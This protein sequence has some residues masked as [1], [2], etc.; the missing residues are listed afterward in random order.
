[1]PQQLNKKLL[2]YYALKAHLRYFYWQCHPKWERNFIISL[3]VLCLLIMLVKT[4]VTQILKRALK[5]SSRLLLEAYHS[6]SCSIFYWIIYIY[7]T[8]G[9]EE[10][11]GSEYSRERLM[12]DDANVTHHDP[13]RTLQELRHQ[14]HTD[15]HYYM[16]RYFYK[17]IPFIIGVLLGYCE[18]WRPKCAEVD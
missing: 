5:K 17:N 15:H 1:M 7:F 6:S 10:H 2:E 11:Q 14:R 9:D 13:T 4:T 8:D 12:C 18:T 3:H 16:S